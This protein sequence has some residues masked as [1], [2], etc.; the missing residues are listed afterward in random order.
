MKTLGKTK[1]GHLQT[2]VLVSATQCEIA[3]SVTLCDGRCLRNK[4][5]G[6]QCL[7]ILGVSKVIITRVLFLC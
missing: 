7:G 4:L 5:V 2:S 3:R 6:L 1:K